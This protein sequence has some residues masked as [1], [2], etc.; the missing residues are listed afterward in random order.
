MLSTRT[1]HFRRNATTGAPPRGGVPA[2]DAAGHAEAAA[3]QEILSRSRYSFAARHSRNATCRH[4]EGPRR[5][6]ARAVPAAP[7]P[8][9]MSLETPAVEALLRAHQTH[10]EGPCETSSSLFFLAGVR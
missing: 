10:L 7:E 2:R 3:S 4:A 1:P 6:L 8:E 5:A 9:A